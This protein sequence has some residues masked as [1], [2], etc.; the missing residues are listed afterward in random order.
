MVVSSTGFANTGS[1]A[2]TAVGL[3]AVHT[4]G[5]PATAVARAAIVA[6]QVGVAHIATLNR[7]AGAGRSIEG[8]NVGLSTESAGIHMR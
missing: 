8:G 1:Q 3:R 5:R 7:E 2:A 4:L 6:L